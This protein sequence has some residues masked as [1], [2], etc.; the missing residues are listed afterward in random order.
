M[1]T[2]AE[3]FCTHCLLPLGLRPT[4][5]EVDGQT[6][7]FCCY[8]CCLAYQVRSGHG[9][10]SEAAWLLV[11]LGVG[12]FL[13]MNIMLFSLLLYSGTFDHADT[14]LVPVVHYVLWALATPLIVVL[15]GPLFR[16]TWREAARG[17]LTSFSLIALGAGAAYGYSALNTLTGGEH[18]YFDTAT[19]VLVLYTL[20]RYLEAVG[21]ARA[22]RNLKPMLEAEGQWVRVIEDGAEVGRPVGEMTAGTMVRV[23]PG[24][25][26]PVDGVVLDGYSHADEAAITGESR[27]V[28]K[29]LG[30]SVFAGSINQEGPLLIRSSVAG[31]ATQ[32]AR[33]CN[34]V[35]EAL[36]RDTPTQ[37]LADQVASGFVPAVLVVAG[38]TVLYWGSR[39]PFDEA[40]MTGLAVLV[41]ACPCALGLAAPLAGSLGIGRLARRG[42]LARSGGVLETLSRVQTVVF[43]K[44]GTLTRGKARLVGVEGEGASPNEIL[45]RAAGLENDSEHTLARG[46][47][48]AA[49]HRRLQPVPARQVRAIPGRGI[50]GCAEGY[51]IAAGN[52]KLMAELNWRIPP[53]LVERGR[54]AEAIGQ[55]VVYVGWRTEVKGVLLLDDILLPE[56]RSIVH[57][58]R[59]L[60]LRTE[61]LTGDLRQVARR[62]ASVVGMDKWEAGMTPQDKSTALQ[63]CSRTHGPVAMV[64]DGLNDGPV[65]AEAAVGI[66]V[67]SATDLARETA[68]LVLPDGGLKI[69]PWVIRLARAVRKTIVTN[70]LWAFGYN[71][72]AIALAVLGLLQPV[73]AAALM[74]GS[75]IVV[76]FNSLRVERFPD[77]PTDLAHAKSPPVNRHAGRT[78]MEVPNVKEGSAQSSIARNAQDA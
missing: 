14:H 68:D 54:S 40:L 78:P 23:R 25:R 64:G 72:V 21:R 65:L 26:I 22:V 35:R 37:R 30:S 4:Q 27:L 36:A 42:C 61:L 51:P 41:V 77:P 75:S 70:L 15:G 60:G 52:A 24:E 69:L 63:R 43:D 8:G 71:L 1:S 38:L 45:R 3:N 50:V 6:Y 10:E 49:G 57:T 55:T 44:T 20:G 67:R 11:R 66:A 74:A 29:I 47:I 32:W 73:I 12:G 28:E 33:I 13:A 58:L 17:R 59:H 18:V 34:S 31:T 2:I 46:I 16:E 53:A 7:A 76:V 62:V 56:A 5:R 39:V 19:M 9:E 48:E